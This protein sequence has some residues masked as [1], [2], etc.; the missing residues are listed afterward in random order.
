MGFIMGQILDRLCD[1]NYPPFHLLRAFLFHDSD[2]GQFYATQ[3]A[4]CLLATHTVEFLVFR[5]HIRCFSRR[6]ELLD[7]LPISEHILPAEGATAG[8][9]RCQ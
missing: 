3:R 6:I 7:T 2:G 8:Q 9:T 5:Y 1:N 4:V